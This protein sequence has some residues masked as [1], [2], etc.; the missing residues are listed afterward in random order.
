MK[1]LLDMIVLDILNKQPM[2]GYQIIIKIRKVFGVYYGPSAI[3]PLLDALEKKGVVKSAWNTDFERPRKIYR[4]TNYGESILN[5]AEDSLTLI[6]KTMF[7]D[8][9]IRMEAATL[10]PTRIRRQ[11]EST[12]LNTLQLGSPPRQ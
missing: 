3:Y 9:G 6:R 4:L 10:T 11:Y 7:S 8:E 2:H 1:G 5:F 12:Q